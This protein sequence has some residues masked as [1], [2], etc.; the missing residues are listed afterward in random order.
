MLTASSEEVQS[1][2]IGAYH[3]ALA[4]QWLPHLPECEGMAREAPPQSTVWARELVLD[5]PRALLT[6]LLAA[7]LAEGLL[8]CL[9]AVPF[10][11]HTRG[12]SE[13]VGAVRGTHAR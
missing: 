7:S 3:W 5:G 10:C 11:C 9:V 12:S 4:G 8:H 13:P 6:Y 2:W 1:Y